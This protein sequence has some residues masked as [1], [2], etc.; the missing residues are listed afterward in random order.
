MSK[1]LTNIQL[2]LPLTSHFLL[3]NNHSSHQLFVKKF[4]K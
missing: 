4:V 2:D 1:I 3:T